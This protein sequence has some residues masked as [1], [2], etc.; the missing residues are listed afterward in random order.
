MN[1]EVDLAVCQNYSALNAS[2]KPDISVKADDLVAKMA[3]QMIN[4]GV[5]P[6]ANKAEKRR[7]VDVTQLRNEVDT[8]KE[9]IDRLMA[10]TKEVSSQPGTAALLPLGEHPC[11][12][13]TDLRHVARSWH[14]R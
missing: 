12:R 13:P 14:C 4:E 6:I 3:K 5:K 10:R 2:I 7:L 9:V 8:Q 1:L 11:G